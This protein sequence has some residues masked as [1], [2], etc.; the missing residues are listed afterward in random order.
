M[1]NNDNNDF[2]Y[3]EQ[4]IKNKNKKRVKKALAVIALTL[5]AAVAF[6]FISRLVFVASESTVNKIL[7][8]TPVPSPTPSETPGRNEVTLDPRKTSTPTPSPV[9]EAPTLTPTTIPVI[10][11]ED[12]T[13]EPTE[14]PTQEPTPTDEITMTPEPTGPVN[15][16][17]IPVEPIDAYLKMISQM[18]LVASRASESLVRVYAVTSGVNWMDE[19]IETRTERTGILCADN[20]VELLILTE[21]TSFAAAD[22]I[23]IEFRDGTVSEGTVYCADPDTG[24][25]VIAVELTDISAST[26]ATCIYITLGDSD[27]VY[28]G[29]PVIAV[30]RPNGYYG[31]VEFGFVSHTGLLKYFIDGVQ[32]RFA[33]DIISGDNADGMIVDLEGKLVGLIVHEADA[34]TKA[35]TVSAVNINSLKT[36]LLK[37]LNGNPLPYFG[38][39]AENVPADILEG[40]GL[41]NGIYV[42]EVISSSPASEAGVKKG[43]VIVAI[44]GEKI[45]NVSEFYEYIFGLE[46]GTGISLNIYHSGMRDEPAEEISALISVK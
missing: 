43:D 19:S 14:E 29:Q 9:T 44:D 15:N 13:K 4:K 2:N 18:R 41:E 7:G 27:N 24:L 32:S 17:V 45:S 16:T 31:A 34:E 30:G 35:I 6:G 25:A 42:N 10:L 40:M 23:E 26:I 8:I 38:V 46:E 5:V 36:L 11:P 12:P 39:R 37:L 28:E 22:R 20:G 21:Y 1:D 33:T 3:V